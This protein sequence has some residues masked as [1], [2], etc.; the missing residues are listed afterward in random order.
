M[1]E[2]TRPLWLDCLII[3][4]IIIGVLMLLAVFVVGGGN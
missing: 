3:F 1:N 2:P 4:G